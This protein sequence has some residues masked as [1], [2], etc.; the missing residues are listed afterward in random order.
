MND[1][2]QTMRIFPHVPVEGY[3][4]LD[5]GAGEK[6]ERVGGTVLRRPDPQ[7]MWRRVLAPSAWEAADLVFV[8]ESDRG[9]RWQRGRRGAG[10][11]PD[12]WELAHAGARFVLRPTPF[13]HLGLF[14]EQSTNWAWT[15]ER[16]EALRAGRGRATATAGERPAVLN[17]FAY[18]GAATVMATLAGGFVTH[19]DASRPALRWA[20]ENAARSGLAADAVR[21][22]EDDVPRFVARERRRGRRYHGILLDPPPYGRGPA[23]EKWVF[24]ER[25]AELVEACAPLLEDDGAFL[26]LSCYAVGTSPLAFHNLLGDLGDG[27]V[28]AGE[29]ALPFADGRRLLPAGLCGRWWREAAGGGTGSGGGT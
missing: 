2:P 10:T 14:P 18:T 29:L 25:V 23:N 4:L 28:E 3:E 26:V 6:L 13:K 15:A 11:I 8:R 22:I 21:W 1:I 27:R 24:E 19:V 17:L 12:E 16:L 7:A 5:C 9:G 20:R